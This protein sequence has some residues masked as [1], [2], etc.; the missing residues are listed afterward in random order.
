MGW[1]SAPM[2]FRW[3]GVRHSCHD[4][5]YKDVNL[6]NEPCEGCF[7]PMTTVP[8]S[9]RVAKSY[10]PADPEK[11]QMIK[12]MLEKYRGPIREMLNDLKQNGLSAADLEFQLKKNGL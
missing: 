3:D 5:K 10:T 7:R 8:F 4:C 1:T 11:H 2:D 6:P 9:K 12:G